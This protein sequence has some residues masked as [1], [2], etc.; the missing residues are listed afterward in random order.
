MYLK[1]KNLILK[2]PSG[3]GATRRVNLEMLD[4]NEISLK[5]TPAL[6]QNEIKSSTVRI[7]TVGNKV[8][9]ALE[10][11]SN[12]IDSRSDTEGFKVIQLT[13]KQENQIIK[14]NKL[15]G[16]NFS[17]WDALIDENG[18]IFPVDGNPGP[19]IYW[20]GDYL[21]RVV[22][23]KLAQFM[24][25]FSESNSITLANKSITKSQIIHNNIFKIDKNLLHFVEKP[26]NSWKKDLGLRY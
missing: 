1:N 11:I 14:A 24:V 20:I 4:R 8:I 21:T 3:V 13:K 12:D 15:L 25:A 17:A 18:K 23:S 22:M 6:F 10:I 16:W 5:M 26:I 19:Y 9:L 7:H 2:S